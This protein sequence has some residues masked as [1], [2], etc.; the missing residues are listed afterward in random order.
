MNTHR[1]SLNLRRRQW[2]MVGLISVINALFWGWLW[3]DVAL[4]LE[5]YADREPHFEEIVPMYKFG[6]QAVPFT[7]EHAMPS[8]R[9]MRVIQQPTHIAIVGITNGLTR[10]STWDQRWGSISIGSWVLIGTMMVSF[11]Q[12]GLIA[13]LGARFL[14]WHK[15]GERAMKG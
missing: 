5:P 14:Q 2:Q 1:R 9:T 6:G 4:H 12:W 10:E 15:P 7:S 11:L 8:L 13:F 3:I